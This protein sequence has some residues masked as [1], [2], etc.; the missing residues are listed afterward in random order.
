MKKTSSPDSIKKTPN[1]VLELKKLPPGLRKSLLLIIERR[2]KS[3]SQQE[4]YIAPEQLV[5]ALR[6]NPGVPLPPRIHSYLCDFLEGK[7]KKPGGR[8]PDSQSPRAM[9]NKHLIPV[10]YKR[11]YT[12][13]EKRKKPIDPNGWKT[14]K[15]AD[16]WQGPPSERA[17]RMTLKRLKLSIGWRRVLNIVSESKE[18]I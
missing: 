15:K 7:I 5:L 3:R 2:L 6:A 1:E 4:V 13:L 11:Y 9:I 16:W 10:F 12:W 17:A 14:I 18:D 8:P